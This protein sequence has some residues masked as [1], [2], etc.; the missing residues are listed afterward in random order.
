MYDISTLCTALAS[1]LQRP[2]FRVTVRTRRPEIADGEVERVVV[3]TA[4]DQRPQIVAGRGEQA[5]VDLAD[6]AEP[7]PGA[8]AAKR[9]ADRRDDA[10]L[11]AAVD[12]PEAIRHLAGILR[13]Q[14]LRAAS[15]GRAAR[16]SRRPERL[17]R[18]A[19][20]S[21]RRRPCTRCTA[22]TWPCSRRELGQR[23]D[24]GIV[25][26]APDHRVELDRRETRRRRGRDTGQHGVEGDFGVGHGREGRRVES[27]EAHRDA[28]E[29]GV[30]QLLP[31]AGS[32]TNRWL[33]SAMSSMPSRPRSMATRSGRPARNSGSPPV[34]RTL[35]HTGARECRNDPSD[36]FKSKQ[37]VARHEGKPGTED[38]ARHAIS[39]AH[40][41]AIGHRHPQVAN[42]T[43]A[44]IDRLQPLVT[45]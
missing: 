5:G 28:A 2:Q 29:P 42:R 44:R 18:D 11:A 39:T 43:A 16:R 15:V 19:S 36:L 31:R 27:V 20:R 34:S 21:C 26:A 38:F 33:S 8:V 14:W 24:V 40:V 23:L 4:S 25:P 12:V 41:A 1:R 9:L 32:T 30:A 35:R 45:I 37:L 10:D 3:R 13:R 6:R 17:R 22:S 7:G